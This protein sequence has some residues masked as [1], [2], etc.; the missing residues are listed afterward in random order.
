[1]MH[2]EEQ[3]E[4]W[5]N[6]VIDGRRRIADFE[7]R[8]TYPANPD[9]DTVAIAEHFRVRYSQARI[10][11]ALSFSHA[12]A[13]DELCDITGV[14]PALIKMEVHHTSR[15]CGFPIYIVSGPGKKPVLFRITSEADCARIRAIVL[16]S[17]GLTETFKPQSRMKIAA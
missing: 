17:W 3:I 8:A 6:A 1:M 4:I 5:R 7:R 14:H 9:P 13:A 10:L 15:R 16:L 12:V 11:K 2:R